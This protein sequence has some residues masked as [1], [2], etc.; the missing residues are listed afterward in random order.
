MPDRIT[1]RAMSRGAVAAVVVAAGA[2]LLTALPDASIGAPTPEPQ[3]SFASALDRAVATLDNPDG[4]SA[5]TVGTVPVVASLFSSSRISAAS[6]RAADAV[7]GDGSQSVPRQPFSTTA[8]IGT[9]APSYGLRPLTDIRGVATTTMS[10][11]STTAQSMELVLRLPA[12]ATTLV[13]TIWVDLPTTMPLTYP[14]ASAVLDGPPQR[15]LPVASVTTSLLP[16]TVVKV[17]ATR[18]KKATKTTPAVPAARATTMVVP[19]HRHVV[20][21][22]RASIAVG[23]SGVLRL[24]LYKLTTPPTAGAYHLPITVIGRRGAT[25]AKGLATLVLAKRPGAPCPTMRPANAIALENAKAGSSVWTEAVSVGSSTSGYADR[26]SVS[27]GE[28]VNLRVSSSARF[29]TVWAWRMGGY[30]GRGARLVFRTGPVLGGPRAAPVSEAAPEPP[31]Q[32]DVAGPAQGPIEA[33]W[34]VSLA[35]PITGEFTPGV[36][37]LQVRGSDGGRTWIPLVVK[38]RLGTPRIGVVLATNTWQAYNT[39]GGASA[40]VGPD[41]RAETRSRIVSF[42]RPY[43]GRGDGGMVAS[44]VPFVRWAE[45]RG[46]D[47]TYLTDDDLD[48]GV[49]RLRAVTTI[50]VPG[51]SEYWTAGMRANLESMVLARGG[52]VAFLGAN[53]VYW[54]PRREASPLGAGRRL[55]IYRIASQDPAGGDPSLSSTR[56]RDAPIAN[57][58]QQT[59]GAQYA[60]LGVDAALVVPNPPDPA[61]PPGQGW[62]FDTSG[63]PTGTTL[64]HLGWG[65]VDRV[66]SGASDA[67]PDNLRSL[68]Q[69]YAPCPG[70]VAGQTPEWDITAYATPSGGALLDMGTLGWTC[71]LIGDCSFSRG[72]VATETFVQNVTATILD[73]FRPGPAGAV[74]SA[75]GVPWSMLPDPNATPTPTPTPSPTDTGSPS[76]SPSGSSCPSPSPTGTGSPSPSPSASGSSCPS[77]SPT[78]TGSPSPSGSP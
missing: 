47:V 3:P 76:P 36:Y 17:A 59:L 33:R 71:Q 54:R 48:A 64:A 61:A 46:Y 10:T 50:V 66:W 16:R 22:L 57:P 77:P 63:V 45:S 1:A 44:E 69:T 26:T 35:L 25:T 15:N 38:D 7:P 42:D 32:A 43:S 39:W 56:W 29:F 19:A 37:L 67:H 34:P 21:T 74:V 51:H 65:E 73:T 70:A 11:V 14:T 55:D 68:A 75:A 41:G 60:C 53:N 62:P 27:C 72:D 8:P 23:K 4:P 18:A 12:T 30:S 58:E 20:V 78:G 24:W 40:Y 49:G 9:R 2:L 6:V 13:R 28:V 31:N 52:N 5:T